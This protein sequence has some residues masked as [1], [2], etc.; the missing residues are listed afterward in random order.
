[1]PHA[2]FETANGR[3][4]YWIEGE[5]GPLPTLVFLPGLTC[6]HRAF[7]EQR[8]LIEGRQALF[9]DAPGHGLSRPYTHLNAGD[10]V[11]A[12]KGILDREG[13][14]QVLLIGHSLGGFLAWLFAERWPERTAGVIAISAPP[15]DENYY[16]A[17][18]RFTFAQW[19]NW[20]TAWPD[21]MLR[22]GLLEVCASDP[23]SLRSMADM[24]APY[25]AGELRR[26][27]GRGVALIG[28]ALIPAHYEGPQLLISGGDDRTG[29]V[30]ELN[31]RQAAK[32]GIPLEIIKGA[33]HNTMCE[34]PEE[35]N[36]LIESFIR[37]HYEGAEEARA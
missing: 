26:L 20:L 31:R 35:V 1:M 21:P 8:P 37:S 13:I 25:T 32:E 2:F 5:K 14:E 23:A 3:V 10:M 9:W 7:S 16:T 22:E 36:A 18:D 19:P 12:L 15:L 6:D 33:S 27:I 24:I 30:L 28:E 17:G 34:A 29:R 4:A 11:L